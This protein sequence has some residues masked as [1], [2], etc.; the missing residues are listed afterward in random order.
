MMPEFVHG[1]QSGG[2]YRLSEIERKAE[3]SLSGPFGDAMILDRHE[4]TRRRDAANPDQ[5]EYAGQ[6]EERNLLD[7]NRALGR[8]PPTPRFGGQPSERVIIQREERQ[9]QSDRG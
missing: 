9:R 7:Q 8:L 5:G 4:I 6:N 1:H 2:A 3:H